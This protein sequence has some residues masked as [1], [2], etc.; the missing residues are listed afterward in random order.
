MTRKLQFQRKRHS[1]PTSELVETG[2]VDLFYSVQQALQNEG[3]HLIDLYSGDIIE[4][5]VNIPSLG[6]IDGHKP[7]K[8]RQQMGFVQATSLDSI[9][10]E[11]KDL[12]AVLVFD[13]NAQKQGGPLYLLIQVVDYD[14][15]DFWNQ[16]SLTVARRFIVNVH[17]SRYP[18]VFFGVTSLSRSNG[19]DS[20]ARNAALRKIR[21]YSLNGVD[22]ISD[23][24]ILFDDGFNDEDDD[25][26][27]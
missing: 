2:S 18:E 11:K 22:S 4:G 25:F 26:E 23:T 20:S 5:Q 17:S 21:N 8:P 14:D 3:V 9:E 15:M 27:C 7:L 12:D 6:L 10:F 1:I 19:K 13:Q 16:I 24:E